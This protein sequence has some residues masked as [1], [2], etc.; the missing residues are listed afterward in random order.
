MH[1]GKGLIDGK[2]MRAQKRPKAEESDHMTYR[3]E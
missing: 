3:K 2:E 1:T